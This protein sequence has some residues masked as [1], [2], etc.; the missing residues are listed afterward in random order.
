MGFGMIPACA[1]SLFLCHMEAAGQRKTETCCY[2]I[3]HGAA[4]IYSILDD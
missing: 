2:G 3:I 1:L 4:H